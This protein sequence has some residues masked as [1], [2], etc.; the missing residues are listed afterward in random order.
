M[1]DTP[2]FVRQKCVSVRTVTGTFSCAWSLA[3]FT[4]GAIVYISHILFKQEFLVQIPLL[5]ILLFVYQRVCFPS[6]WNGSFFLWTTFVCLS[7]LQGK[8]HISRLTATGIFSTWRFEYLQFTRQINTR[9][10]DRRDLSC[11]R[12][13]AMITPQAKHAFHLRTENTLHC[14]LH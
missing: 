9:L 6:Y 8:V 14:G 3:L 5:D 10:S 11:V 7:N 12:C 13:W 2:Y 1:L 4:V